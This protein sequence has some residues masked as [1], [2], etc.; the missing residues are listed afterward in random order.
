M[1]EPQPL[2]KEELLKLAIQYGVSMPNNNGLTNYLDK[3]GNR[4]MYCPFCGLRKGWQPFRRDLQCRKCGRKPCRI[5]P[6]SKRRCREQLKMR[7]VKMI[8]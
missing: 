2:P 5:K 8:E 1:S 6:K 7:V 3:F 4:R